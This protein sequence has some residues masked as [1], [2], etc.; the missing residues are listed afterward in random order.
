MKLLTKETFSLAESPRYIDG[1]V[2]FT[3]INGKRL[4]CWKDE[5]LDMIWDKEQITSFVADKSGG[6]T[7]ATMH[8]LYYISIDGVCEELVSDLKINDMC[9]D[10]KGRVVF[11]TNYHSAAQSYPLGSLYVYDRKNGLRELDYG[12][13][14]S[15]GIGFSPDGTKMY[16]CDSSVQTVFEYPYDVENGTCGRKR[17][18]VRFRGNEGW[19]DGMAID[20]DGCIWTAQW[21]GCC[22]IRTSPDG[23]ELQRI[24]VP[25]SKPSAVEFTPDGLFITTAYGSVPGEITEKEGVW[26]AE[27]GVYRTETDVA[28][29]P[30]G[31][32]DVGKPNG[33]RVGRI[34]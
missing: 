29:Q 11:G 33:T 9:A 10:P 31:V 14:L 13:H 22:V 34:L 17:I 27:G 32:S 5:R 2:V 26:Y 7:F 12:I 8:G 16:L 6:M 19:P 20:E 30:H 21:G 25:A 23:Q 4:Y 1:A 3:D 24:P 28:G 18:L 15:N